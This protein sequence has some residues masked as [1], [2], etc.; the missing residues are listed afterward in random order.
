MVHLH[1]CMY[2]STAHTALGEREQIVLCHYYLYLDIKAFKCVNNARLHLFVYVDICLLHI[3]FQYFQHL[4]NM[5]I[6]I[7]ISFF[8]FI[9]FHTMLST[10][11]RLQAKVIM[12]RPRLPHARKKYTRHILPQTPWFVRYFIVLYCTIKMLRTAPYNAALVLSPFYDWVF[13]ISRSYENRS[14]TS[15]T[16]IHTYIAWYRSKRR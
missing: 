9:T 12:K 16:N 10:G 13:Q 15:C 7:S 5:F 8:S 3:I 2:R 11:I 1:V 4:L 6:S 14:A